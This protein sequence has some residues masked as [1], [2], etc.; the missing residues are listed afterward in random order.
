MESARKEAEKLGAFIAAGT[1][2][3]HAV[4]EAERILTGNGFTELKEDGRFTI[5]A[6]KSYFIQRGESALIAF[7]VPKAGWKG[8]SIIASHTDSPAFRIKTNPE[9]Q[10]GPYTVLNTEGYGGML[11]APWFDRPLSVSG[12]VAVNTDH[13][14]EV[15][16]YDSGRDLLMIP[17]LAIHMDRK[18]NEGIHY[19]AQNDLQPLY[20]LSSSNADFL[21]MVADELGIDKERILGADLGLYAR[22]GISFWGHKEEFFSAPRIDNLSSVWASVEAIISAE[23]NEYMPMIALFD[24]EET[25]S[26]TRCGALS[27]FLPSA[28][29]RI[30]HA[31]SIDREK[32]LMVRAS[33]F[34]LSSD[35]GHA[36]HPNHAEKADPTNRPYPN[37][38]VLIKYSAAQKYMT[39][40]YS[41]AYVKKLCIDNG[42]PFQVFHNHSDIPGGS[43]LGNLS[44]EAFSVIGADVGMAQLAMHSPY[45]SAGTEDPMNMLRLFRVFLG[46]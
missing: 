32:E 1:S 42:I 46:R 31:L 38:G 45:E 22:D 14:I 7:R 13:G 6:G 29:S 4:R 12:R 35:N 21:A 28:V 11:M 37:G 18:A 24:N 8:L 9:I 20:A 34:M 44:S 15:K 27:D 23:G 3:Y 43:T 41:G 19:S 39:D 36:L 40:S 10:K 33:S 30:C 2:P 25:G 5:E 16:L 17:S 26:G